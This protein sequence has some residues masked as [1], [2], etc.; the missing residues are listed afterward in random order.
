MVECYISWKNETESITIAF[1]AS[2]V[3][4]AR[5]YVTSEFCPTKDYPN[6]IDYILRFE[7]GSEVKGEMPTLTDC[8]G[9]PLPPIDQ[10]GEDD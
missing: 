6:G 1:S 3:V 10:M 7:D 5:D 4:E 9:E 8:D 2:T